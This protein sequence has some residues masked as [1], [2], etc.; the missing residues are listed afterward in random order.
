MATSYHEHDIDHSQLEEDID[1]PILSLPTSLEKAS[2]NCVFIRFKSM[3]KAKKGAVFQS[4]RHSASAGQDMLDALST[5]QWESTRSKYTLI[6][7][8]R[9]Y[10]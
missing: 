1:T 10:H 2:L 7:L 5:L 8:Q 6:C 9:G 4:S 3:A